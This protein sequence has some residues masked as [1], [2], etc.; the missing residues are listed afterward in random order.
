M[1]IVALLIGGGTAIYFFMLKKP[2]A[3]TKGNDN[4]D[5]YDFGKNKDDE[6]EPVPGG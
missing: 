1:F 2:K 5:D 3:D 6:D 4:Q